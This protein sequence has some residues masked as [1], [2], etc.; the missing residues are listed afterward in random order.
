MLNVPPEDSLIDRPLLKRIECP[1]SRSSVHPLLSEASKQVDQRA[2]ASSLRKHP[3][4][5]LCRGENDGP[6]DQHRRV[7]VVA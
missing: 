3:P 4:R 6:S 7:R 5:W 1:V 2:I